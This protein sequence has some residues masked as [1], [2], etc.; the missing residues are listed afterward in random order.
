M[1]QA[2]AAAFLSLLRADAS[3]TVYPPVEPGG[4]DGIVPQGAE[5]PYVAVHVNVLRPAGDNLPN[6]ST[7]TVARA[8][9]HSAGGNDVAARIVA[10]RV[11]AALLDVVPTI[12]G[13]VCAPIRHEDSRPPAPDETTGN[14]VIAQVDVYRLET[15]P[16]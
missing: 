14:T 4:S 12:A 10:Q 1:I 16:A 9:C 2:H 7:R 8:Y 15:E 13:R 3:L 11:S 6:R 5:P